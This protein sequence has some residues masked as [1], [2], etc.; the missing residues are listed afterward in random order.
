MIDLITIAL[1]V[2][3]G[4][5]MYEVISWLRTQTITAMRKVSFKVYWL[6]FQYIHWHKPLPHG[7]GKGGHLV[8]R[9]IFNVEQKHVNQNTST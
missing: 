8:R 6:G 2:F 1:G 3:I 5:L 9:G 7:Q 4:M